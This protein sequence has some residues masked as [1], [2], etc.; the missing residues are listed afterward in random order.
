MRRCGDPA[1]QP[2]PKNTPE[3]LC[4]VDASGRPVIPLGSRNISGEPSDFNL[5][6]T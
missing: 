3:R 4:Q 1:G 6:L 2:I 5:L